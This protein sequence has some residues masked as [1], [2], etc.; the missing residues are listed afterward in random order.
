MR[1]HYFEESELVNR[2]R[3]RF[4]I[5]KPYALPWGEWDEWNAQTKKEK[6]F[7]YFIT[8]TLP[9]FLDKC[10]NKIPT[11]IDDIRYYCRNR[12]YR[13]SH[14][15]PC[16]FKPGEYHD[17]DERL[18]HGVMNSLVDFVEIE[19]AYKSRW[20]NTEESKTAKWRNGRCP[21][22]GL[23]YLAWE[24]TLDS[25]ELDITERSDSQAATAREIKEIYDW[26]KVTRPAR[27]DP[28]DASG[29]SEYCRKSEAA[30]YTIFSN[31]EK[32]PEL[33]AMS[34]LT[35]KKLREIEAAYDTEDEDML[36]RVIKIR[37]S[38]WA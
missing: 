27:P 19:K 23:E 31:K 11:P 15:L 38:L 36:I 6:P 18:L 9:E 29:W 12:F 3:T 21:E 33:A 30:G 24:M 13:K 28:Y 10:L 20:C 1:R 25:E 16:Y 34:D 5:V 4:G 8:E 22:L 7:A 2:L 32:D 14:V 26:W 35:H 17:L 37:R